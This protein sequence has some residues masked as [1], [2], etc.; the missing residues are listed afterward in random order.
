MF[1]NTLLT[2]VNVL[3]SQGFTVEIIYCDEERGF[4]GARPALEEKGLAVAKGDHVGVAEGYQINQRAGK[5]YYCRVTVHYAKVIYEVSIII[6]VLEL[7]PY[8]ELF[9]ETHAAQRSCLGGLN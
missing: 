3:K 8:H 6:L 4:V 9:P 1:A 7:M 5:V 2:Q